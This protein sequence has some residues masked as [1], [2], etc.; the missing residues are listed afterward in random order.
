MSWLSLLPGA[1][2]ILDMDEAAAGGIEAGGDEATCSGGDACSSGGS[3]D[4]VDRAISLKQS[5]DAAQDELDELPPSEACAVDMRIGGLA[6][7]EYAATAMVMDSRGRKHKRTVVFEAALPKTR[8]KRKHSL[9]AVAV[10]GGSGSH[11][12]GDRG[13]PELSITV[14]GS[15][16]RVM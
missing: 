5:L 13:D 2:A 4:A 16:C 11:D 3:G 7:G 1:E 6:P 10:G 9:P 14:D 15:G 8:G 12:S